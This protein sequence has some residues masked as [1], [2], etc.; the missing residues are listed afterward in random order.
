MVYGGYGD[1]YLSIPGGGYIRF[2]PVYIRDGIMTSS[3]NYLL[4]LLERFYV[5]KVVYF[6]L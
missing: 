6:S 1:S 5:V 3:L 4:F 2:V